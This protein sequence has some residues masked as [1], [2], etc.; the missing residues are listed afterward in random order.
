ME[1]KTSA[2]ALYK[3]ALPEEARI[4]ELYEQISIRCARLQQLGQAVR[5]TEYDK[6]FKGRLSE[7]ISFLQNE[8]QG[9]RVTNAVE[10]LQL[11]AQK[12]GLKYQQQGTSI[13]LVSEGTFAFAVGINEMRNVTGAKL[14]LGKDL[15]KDC[16]V[17]LELLR[18][19]QYRKVGEHLG[20][21]T[22]LSTRLAACPQKHSALTGLFV[23]ESILASMY[24]SNYTK[25][26]DE[27]LH[28]HL[29]HVIPR[30]GGLPMKLV[31]Y[32]APNDLLDK[33]ELTV[34]DPVPE[35]L[36]FHL[37]ILAEFSPQVNILPATVNIFN[38]SGKMLPVNSQNGVVAQA[39]LAMQLSSNVPASM[40]TIRKIH[41]QVYGSDQNFI[42]PQAK[43]YFEI[44]LATTEGNLNFS[45]SEARVV[46]LPSQRHY[47]FFPT[48]ATALTG[49]VLSKVSFLHPFAVIQIVSLLRQQLVF[50]NLIR[51]CF[52]GSSSNL[53]PETSDTELVCSIMELTPPTN[54]KFEVNLMGG[55]PVFIEI[56]IASSKPAMPDVMLGNSPQNMEINH[57]L[58]KVLEK[59]LSIP[60][61]LYAYVKRLPQLQ[62]STSLGGGWQN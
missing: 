12:L 3:L 59:C 32:G 39:M 16:H 26:V 45:S 43:S 24:K 5:A 61:M 1:N 46:H 27:I 41:A 13:L 31:I 19:G 60:V 25:L 58:I 30:S 62:N 40:V 20:A 55:G 10:Q 9:S 14:M 4:K 11:L 6:A 48:S 37:T 44:L 51:S 49:D 21:L 47:Y 38:A 17:M 53:N 8:C 23:I 35:G 36:G 15:E 57:Y 18:D 54:I 33:Q 2:A 29:G 28:S 34:M 52:G 42:A 50:N 56:N 7:A 22:E